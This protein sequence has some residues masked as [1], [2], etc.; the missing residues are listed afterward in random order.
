VNAGRHGND[1]IERTALPNGLIRG[2]IRRFLKPG[3][4]PP[5]SA[6]RPAQQP[7]KWIKSS[8]WVKDHRLV[9]K[10]TQVLMLLATSFLEAA[11]SGVH[12]A[13]GG[14]VWAKS[15]GGTGNDPVS[16]IAVGGDG[17]EDVFISKLNQIQPTSAGGTTSFHDDDSG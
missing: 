9:V 8:Y 11:G 1:G 6:G 3:I 12:A 7:L 14:F 4:S 16:G 10:A 5:Q 15:M 2:T 13:N 17:D